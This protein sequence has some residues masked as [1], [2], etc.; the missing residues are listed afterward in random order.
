MIRQF[1]DIEPDD[2]GEWNATNSS[3]NEVDYWA[4]KEERL[5]SSLL[6]PLSSPLAG[7]HFSCFVT[8]FSGQVN[9]NP[10]KMQVGV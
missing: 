5:M 1:E 7:P 2:G 6:S 9:L 4:G 8:K 3:L 10:D